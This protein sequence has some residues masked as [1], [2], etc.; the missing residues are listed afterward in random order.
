MKS[1]EVIVVGAGPAGLVAAIAARQRGFDVTVLDARTPPIDKPCGEG[2]LPQGVAALQSLGISLPAESTFPFRGI[3]FVD[4]GRCARADF[5]SAPGFSMRRVKLHQFL[6]DRAVEAGVELQWGT[7]VTE[8]D[9]AEVTTSRGGVFLS[10]AHWSG[11][12]ELARP[13]MGGA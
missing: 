5:S 13:E 7:R 11:R 12:P 4:A 9:D 1:R 10:L 3:Q 6:L 2:I 8:I